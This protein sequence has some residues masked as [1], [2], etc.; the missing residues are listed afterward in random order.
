MNKEEI[1]EMASQVA[2]YLVA[3]T[4]NVLT[5]DDVCLLTGL[6][7]SY[8]YKL[9][10]HKAIPHYK[11]NAKLV[12][13]NRKEIEQWMMQNRVNTKTDAEQFALAYTTNSN[14]N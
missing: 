5:M 10:C 3:V 12:Y 2:S 6:S 11:P 13:F 9:T 8:L 4:K 7:K 14:N 1:K